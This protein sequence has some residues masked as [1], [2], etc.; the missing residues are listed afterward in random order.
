MRFLDLVEEDHCVGPT[1]DRLRELAS[2]LEP[3]VS[4]RRSDQARHGMLLHVFRHVE[5]DHRTLV[6]EKELRECARRLRLPDTG[7]PKENE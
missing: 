6:V 7:G 1:A 3:H 5:A 4:R 2:F